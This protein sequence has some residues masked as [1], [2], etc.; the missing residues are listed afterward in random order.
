MHFTTNDDFF[1]PRAKPE[2]RPIYLI[3]NPRI[4]AVVLV[5]I[6]FIMTY[7]LVRL[8]ESTQTKYATSAKDLVTGFAMFLRV[9]FNNHFSRA[10]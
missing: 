1:F 10:F 9:P 2:S 3:P 6:F 5:R 4:E 8:T 7:L